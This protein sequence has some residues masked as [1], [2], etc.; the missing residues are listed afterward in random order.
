MLLTVVVII[1][2]VAG[3]KI[4]SSVYS[5]TPIVVSRNDNSKEFFKE[6]KTKLRHT[7][8]IHDHERDPFLGTIK[9]EMPNKKAVPTKRSVKPTK[10]EVKVK[11]AGMVKTGN[12]NEESIFFVNING[13]SN[14]MHIRDEISG[15]KLISGDESEITIV[16]NGKRKTVK[17]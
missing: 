5:D 14:L 6:N 9:S 8:T 4:Y 3:Y 1:W 7:F 12:S 17:K 13:I 16:I 2:G 11:Y 10:P 15:I